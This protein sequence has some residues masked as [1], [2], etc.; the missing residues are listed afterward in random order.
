[1][2][3]IGDAT[4]G[5]FLVA[6]ISVGL[7][8]FGVIKIP[9]NPFYWL[10]DFIIENYFNNSQYVGLIFWIVYVVEASLF[11]IL[12]GFIYRKIKNRKSAI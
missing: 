2:Y 8:L 1:M 5:V 11:G 10:I 9:D 4:L 6:V 7:A 12:I 3:L